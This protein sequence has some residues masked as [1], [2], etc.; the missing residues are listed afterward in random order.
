M[1]LARFHPEP[2]ED[3]ISEPANILQLLGFILPLN[4]LTSLCLIVVELAVIIRPI[5]EDKCAIAVGLSLFEVAN[6][7]TTILFVHRA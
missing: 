7:E 5:G 2:M 6:E 3:I 1:S 4:T